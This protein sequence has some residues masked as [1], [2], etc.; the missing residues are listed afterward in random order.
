MNKKIEQNKMTQAIGIRDGL[1]DLA[2]MH[3]VNEIELHKMADRIDQ[4]AK[5]IGISALTLAD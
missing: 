1:R 3:S 5:Q 4:I 2:V